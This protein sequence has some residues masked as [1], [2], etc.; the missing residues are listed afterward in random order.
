MKTNKFTD[1]VK[2]QNYIPELTIAEHIILWLNVALSLSFFIVQLAKGQYDQWTTW[3]TFV[4]TVMSIF[5]VMA[6]AKQRILCPFLG[7]VSSILLIAIAW[8]NQLP[9][10]MIM[11]G[12]NIIMQ[13]VVFI[14]WFRTSKN[15]VTIQPTQLKLWIVLLYILGFF[16]LTGLFA[17]M[18]GQYWFYNFWF[19]QEEPLH[20]S[21]RIFD[22]VVLMFTVAAFFPMMKKYDF[23]WWIYIICDVG[24]A[25]TWAL[26]A[27][28]VDDQDIFNCW[29]MFISGLSMT[30][31]CILGMINWRKSL[32]K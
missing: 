19:N 23:V 2:K 26:K 14:N 7:I 22:A 16:A 12:F 28:L 11:Y 20:V 10:S 17:W 9:G 30:A 24:I 3:L 13:T 21:I 1:F 29:S 25:T 8:G 5:S 4:A 15:K 27:I 32:K 31:T 18:E 6:G